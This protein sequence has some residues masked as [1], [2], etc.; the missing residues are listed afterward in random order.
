MLTFSF[1]LIGKLLRA[2]CEFI[3]A[4]IISMIL[5]FF[6]AFGCHHVYDLSFDGQGY[7]QDAIITLSEG[8]NFWS[9]QH[10]NSFHARWIDH[11]PKSAW[12]SSSFYFK[13]FGSIAAAKMINLLLIFSSLFLSLVV[14]SHFLK[15]TAAIILLSLLLAFDPINF[16]SFFSFTVDGQVSSLY[17]ILILLF[18]IYERVKTQFILVLIGMVI[19]YSINL[20][21][22]SAAYTVFVCF[23]YLI[24]KV[25]K[26]KT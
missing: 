14:L 21:F 24:W 7:N 13:L 12:L 9:Q 22:T 8:W 25:S 4:F 6:C 26:T 20:K 1:Y 19:I 10:S 5:L 18:I 16:N 3:L 15:S 11:Y 23:A 2:R 17:I